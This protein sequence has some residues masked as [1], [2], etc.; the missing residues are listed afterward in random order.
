M[1]VMDRVARRPDMRNLASTVVI[2][3]CSGQTTPRGRTCDLCL[4]CAHRTAPGHEAMQPVINGRMFDGE[5]CLDF[6]PMPR[7]PLSPAAHLRGFARPVAT[8]L[9]GPFLSI[10]Q[11][12]EKSA[13]HALC[14]GTRQPTLDGHAPA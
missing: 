8:P 11:A 14:G 12:R 1:S 7:K 5:R 2:A 3:K 9:A 6:L 13:T 4:S 10:T